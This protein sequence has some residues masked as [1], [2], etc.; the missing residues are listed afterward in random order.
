MFSR[1]S[2]RRHGL[3][4]EK[5]SRLARA[6]YDVGHLL[7]GPRFVWSQDQKANQNAQRQLSITVIACIVGAVS[8]T[9]AKESFPPFVAV[10]TVWRQV[11]G[12][13]ESNA[14]DKTAANL[15]F[16]TINGTWQVE[17]K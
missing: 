13:G 7:V 10:G 2:D 8:E 15:V 4:V 14:Q 6:I 11:H 17:V 1:L 5:K 12:L 3:L 16:Y 9:S